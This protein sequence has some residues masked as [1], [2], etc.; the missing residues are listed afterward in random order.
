[1]LELW[2]DSDDGGI[3]KAKTFLSAC[4]MEE[5]RYRDESRSNVIYSFNKH[6]LHT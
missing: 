4:D 1:M 3:S 2:I 5:I 6:T